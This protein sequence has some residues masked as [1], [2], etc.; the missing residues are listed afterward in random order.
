MSGISGQNLLM[1]GTFELAFGD[2]LVEGNVAAGSER[3]GF[4]LNGPACSDA[5]LFRNNTV[6]SSIV[7]VWLKSSESSL[8][9]GCTALYNLTAFM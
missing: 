3:V 4:L 2:N 9:A 8:S 5:A 6:H 1:P 7:G